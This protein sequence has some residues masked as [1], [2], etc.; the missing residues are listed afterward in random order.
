MNQIRTA[1]YVSAGHPDKICDQISDAI[2][3]EYLR[4]DPNGRVA[5]ETMGGHG[6]IYV[7]GEVTSKGKIN[8]EEIVSRVYSATGHSDSL[9]IHKN[10]VHQSPEIAGG[11]DSGGAGDQ[12]IMIG[13]ACDENEEMIPQELYLARKLIRNLPTNFGPDAK[14]QVTLNENGEVDV[15]IIS[16]QH[17]P[18]A[19]FAPLRTLAETLNPK[20]IYINPAGKFTVGGF[21]AD[22]GLTGRKLA[23]DN[24]GPQIPIGGGCFSGKDATK[25]DRSAAYMARRIAVDYL[26][27]Y[28]CHEVLVKLAYSIGIAEPVMAIAI[29]NPSV[30][31]SAVEESRTVNLLET[32]EYDLTPQGIIDFLGLKRPIFLETAKRGHFGNSFP[33][34][35]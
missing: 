1:E 25:V 8:I 13:Y 33:W 14:S 9:Q 30:I 12:G 35:N 11:V 32:H 28:K 3:D 31:P 29:I 2:L 18:G 27:K 7:M 23:V 34:D 4:I 17:L 16:A 22:T 5:T 21:A 20:H 19:D 15:V 6:H 10:I 24:Y 26:R